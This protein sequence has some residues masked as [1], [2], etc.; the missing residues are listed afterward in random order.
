[1]ENE[2]E[3]SL[4]FVVRYYKDRR[5]K[6]KE[7][8]RHFCR[9]T[10]YGRSHVIFST[11][12]KIAASILVV[13]TVVF[14]VA[15]GLYRLNKPV[16]KPISTQTD[17]MSTERHTVDSLRMVS[18]YFDHTPVTSA[19]REVGRKY[20]VVLEPSDSTKKITGTI[21]VSDLH[22]AVAVLENTLKIRIII[23]KR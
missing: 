18:F 9:I 7:A 11:P 4:M 6:K 1:M 14:A 20:N 8:Y 3:K 2:I 15:R 5:L 19:L 21:E 16:K 13:A 17:I 12:L 10:G 22:E 23:K